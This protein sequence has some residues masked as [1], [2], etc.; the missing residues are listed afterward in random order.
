VHLS[1]F[2]RRGV[3]HHYYPYRPKRRR[4]HPLSREASKASLVVEPSTARHGPIPSLVM[5]ASRVTFAPRLHGTLAGA[6][7]PRLDQAYRDAS[8]ALAP[9]SSR[10]PAAPAGSPWPRG[11]AKWPSATRAS[12]SRPAIFFGQSPCA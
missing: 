4:R 6:R 5:L 3:V 1:S 2:V 9:I 7:S 10:I 11:Y 8:E 12:R